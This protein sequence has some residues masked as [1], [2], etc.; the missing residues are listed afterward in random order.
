MI[1]KGMDRKTSLKVSLLIISLEED[2]EEI[3]IALEES[4]WLEQGLRLTFKRK[5]G[6]CLIETADDCL[7]DVTVDGRPVVN[8][9]LMSPGQELRINNNKFLLV[10]KETKI[11]RKKVFRQAVSLKNNPAIYFIFSGVLLFSGLSLLER[12]K[13]HP[14]RIIRE[15]VVHSNNVGRNLTTEINDLDASLKMH[16]DDKN[17]ILRKIEVLSHMARVNPELARVAFIKILN[18]SHDQEVLK[19]TNSIISKL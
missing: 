7:A 9:L 4:V 1:S 13:L 14:E 10:P 3:K 16:G 15:Q 19:L 8:S 18:N 2:R 11:S 6:L 12:V 17:Y 5:D